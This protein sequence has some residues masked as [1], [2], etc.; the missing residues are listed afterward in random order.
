MR[1]QFND[2]TFVVLFDAGDK[3]ETRIELRATNSMALYDTTSKVINAVAVLM[4]END[5]N[6]PPPSP[7]KMKSPRHTIMEDTDQIKPGSSTSK[8]SGGSSSKLDVP[9]AVK[10]RDSK[11][12]P[13]SSPSNSARNT[14]EEESSST[15]RSDSKTPRSKKS[16]SAKQDA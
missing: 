6:I 10:K 15:P 9:K 7:R 3:K 5:G 1:I 14:T 12:S 8:L 16:D 11:K 2:G 13:G 4:K